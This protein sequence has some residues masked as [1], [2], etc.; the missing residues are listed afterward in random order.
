MPRRGRGGP[1]R[2]SCSL[3]A[4]RRP[5]RGSTGW[6]R[7][8][9]ACVRVDPVL[10]V[11]RPQTEST[12]PPGR[13]LLPGGRDRGRP[14]HR[15]RGG[16]RRA[17]LGMPAGDRDG[18]RHRSRR[19]GHC[20]RRNGVGGAS[21]RSRRATIARCAGRRRR[22]RRRPVRA[23]RGAPSCSRDVW[24]TSPVARST[25]G[26]VGRWC[27]S[28]PPAPQRAGSSRAAASSWSSACDQA[29]GSPRSWRMPASRRSASTRMKRDATARSSPARDLAPR[30]GCELAVRPDPPIR[31]RTVSDREERAARNEATSRE[32]NER[33]EQAHAELHDRVT[34]GWSAS[35]AWHVRPPDPRTWP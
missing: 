18:H 24:R 28:E 15:Q 20:A 19:R 3:A 5:P 26:R 9:E 13:A 14:V 12:C 2:R 22:D 16:R 11:P 30:H 25:A 35:V 4:R 21:G 23:D 33:L 32:I 6:V 1:S 31:V 7:F 8:C 29:D 34:S 10:P 27:S 17:G